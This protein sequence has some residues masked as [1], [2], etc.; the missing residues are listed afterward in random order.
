MKGREFMAATTARRDENPFCV[1]RQ[2]A[3]KQSSRQKLSLPQC[4]FSGNNSYLGATA[5]TA[6]PAKP[7]PNIRLICAT[8]SA[9]NKN[10]GGTYG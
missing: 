9:Q 1:S 3:S 4:H 5:L 10:Q 6:S 2:S 8:S 7:I